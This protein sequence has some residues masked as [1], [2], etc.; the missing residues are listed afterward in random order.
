MSILLN[1][2]FTSLFTN[3]TTTLVGNQSV[4]EAMNGNLYAQ[5]EKNITGRSN[6]GSGKRR[7]KT[8]HGADQRGFR[9]SIM[10]MRGKIWFAFA[11]L[12]LWM[13]LRMRR[14]ESDDGDIIH[15]L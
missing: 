7:R 3:T 2:R 9:N 15:N 14:R 4:I 8:R 6:G 11:T 5:G 10:T 12:N 13:Y 1:V